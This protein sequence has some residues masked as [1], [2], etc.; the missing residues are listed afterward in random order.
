LVSPSFFCDPQDLV[1]LHLI[2]DVGRMCCE[3]RPAK[4]E[5]P[6]SPGFLLNLPQQCDQCLEQLGMKMILGLLNE[7]EGSRAARPGRR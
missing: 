4:A 7:E 2:D 6:V 1:E 3:N 5:H